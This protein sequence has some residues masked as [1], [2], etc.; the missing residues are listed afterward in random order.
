[1]R[2][3]KF[4]A[5]HISSETSRTSFQDGSNVS[6]DA[7]SE[8]VSRFPVN[9][10]AE[11]ND[12]RA[13]ACIQTYQVVSLCM[14]AAFRPLLATALGGAKATPIAAFLMKSSTSSC[15][16]SSRAF[17]SHDDFKPKTKAPT[18]D[19]HAWID[20]VSPNLISVC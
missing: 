18:T 13:E 10:V 7:R 11:A 5:F 3:A 6:C 17:C 15:I 4:G 8:A 16:G 14:R 1:M 19:T 2:N 20:K 12:L 9:A